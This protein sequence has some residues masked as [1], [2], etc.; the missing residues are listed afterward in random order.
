MK[1][2]LQP[3]IQ[4]VLLA[5][6]AFSVALFAV[7]ALSVTW[8]LMAPVRIAETIFE[9]FGWPDV[10]NIDLRKT[11]RDNRRENKLPN[12]GNLYFRYK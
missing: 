8:R 12:F 11:S 3:D 4:L 6:S 7:M 1:I 2:F 5:E 10:E 9:T